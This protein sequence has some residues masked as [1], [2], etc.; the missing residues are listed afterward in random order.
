MSRSMDAHGRN[1]GRLPEFSPCS[2][3]LVG[4]DDQHRPGAG[5]RP[6][7]FLD[8][9]SVLF[10]S[11]SL[12]LPHSAADSSHFSPLGVELERGWP[13]RNA[14]QFE[15]PGAMRMAACA[16]KPRPCADRA[17]QRRARLSTAFEPLAILANDTMS[18]DR[19]EPKN[20]QDDAAGHGD[21]LSPR[22]N[23]SETPLRGC[24]SFRVHRFLLAF[25]SLRH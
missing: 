10:S 11:V 4:G 1:V 5:R 23:R 19:N 20:L 22:C 12:R 6:R 24:A 8:F 9:A 21:F 7:R 16:R 17:E 18:D 3:L 2:S 15:K 25:S 14:N 13:P